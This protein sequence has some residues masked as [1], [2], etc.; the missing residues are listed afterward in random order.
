MSAPDLDNDDLWDDSEDPP[1]PPPEEDEPEVIS[2]RGKLQD[3]VNPLQ[4]K[5]L[6]DAR[7]AEERR[8]KEEK[9]AKLAAK[10]AAFGGGK[11][12]SPAASASAPAPAPA[13]VAASV[14]ASPKPALDRRMRDMMASGIVHGTSRTSALRSTAR[15][16][17]HRVS[18]MHGRG[19]GDD[20]RG[21]NDAAPAT[22]A[23][24]VETDSDSRYVCRPIA[25]RTRKDCT[26]RNTLS[27][28]FSTFFQRGGGGASET[29]AASEGECS[30]NGSS[31]GCC[32]GLFC[33]AAAAAAATTTRRAGSTFG[34]F[35]CDRC[36]GGIYAHHV[37]GF[38]A[39]TRVDPTKG[40]RRRRRQQWAR[41]ATTGCSSSNCGSCGYTL[42]STAR[43]GY[44]CGRF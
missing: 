32:F 13:P 33:A 42:C 11:A 14:G 24:R 27:L 19:G 8:V 5:M 29:F 38:C 20:G 10:L 31:C 39:C 40:E 22:P 35:S 18:A 6:E 2:N 4:L 17:A 28:S 41:S 1:P 37:G 25:A 12:K 9:E 21:G 30:G 44:T 7:K 23:R 43:I 26:F 3:R 15:G 36:L 16:R 34:F